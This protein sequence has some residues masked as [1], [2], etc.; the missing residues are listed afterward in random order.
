MIHNRLEMA[1]QIA[2]L[3]AEAEL[4]ELQLQKATQKAAEKGREAYLQTGDP[5]GAQEFLQDMQQ[6]PY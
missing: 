6:I 5:A 2:K 4:P 1:L 3:E